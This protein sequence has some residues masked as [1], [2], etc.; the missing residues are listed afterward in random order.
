MTN[1]S[2]QITCSF[3]AI[4]LSYLFLFQFLP[5]SKK[6]LQSRICD[7]SRALPVESCDHNHACCASL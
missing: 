4:F 6:L 7:P 1:T 3:L 5:A 2:K